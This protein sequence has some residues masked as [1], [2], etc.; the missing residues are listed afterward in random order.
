MRKG[1][2]TCSTHV[3]DG[4]ANM[5][6]MLLRRPCSSTILDAGAQGL[7]VLFIQTNQIMRDTGRRHSD[8]EYLRSRDPMSWGP[9]ELELQWLPM[10][11]L[12]LPRR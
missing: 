6:F 10:K 3:R 9:E 2:L 11:Q 8:D 1:K 7:G 12:E 4:L 5:A